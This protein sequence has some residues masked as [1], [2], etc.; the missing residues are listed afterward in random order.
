L[1]TVIKSPDVPLTTLD[2]HR[3]LL[4]AAVSTV[5]EAYRAMEEGA[6][7]IGLF[8]CESL[9]RN[10]GPPGEEDLLNIYQAL[11]AL[12]ALRPP[13]VRL[14]DLDWHEWAGHET[15][16]NP[17]LGRRGIRL[18]L[19][20]PELLRPQLRALLRAAGPFHVLLPFVSSVT[21]VLRV[22]QL[23]N[24]LG[25]ELAARGEPWGNPVVGLMADLPAVLAASDIMCCE[26]NFFHAGDHM[27]RYV[28]GTDDADL[29]DAAFLLQCLLLVERMHRR[30]KKVAV[31]TRLVN[32]P[33]AIPVL[34]GLGFDELTVPTGALAAT[35]QLVRETRHNTA[36]LVAAK[37]TSFW[38]PG[39]AR[40]YAREALARV[41]I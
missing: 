17:A 15:E 19:S 16:K 6:E 40:E 11:A 37:V 30:H 24:D 5:D 26:A 29:F 8:R 1:K 2:G 41:R 22:K 3:V 28:M 25:E 31:S 14:P 23:L 13:V 20:A 36:R 32:E 10:G 4:T 39:Q 21:E 9:Y 34:I 35:R 7:G 27:V 18:L 33:A 38:E 12:D